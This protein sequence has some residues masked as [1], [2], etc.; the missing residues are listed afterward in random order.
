MAPRL[1]AKIRDLKRE[2]LELQDQSR[3]FTGLRRRT[4]AFS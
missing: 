3:N 4:E 2:V 1:G